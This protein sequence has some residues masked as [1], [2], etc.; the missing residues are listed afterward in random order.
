MG[1]R[2]QEEVGDRRTNQFRVPWADR[3]LATVVDGDVM[4]VSNRFQLAAYDLTSG[5]RKWQSQPPPGPIQRSQDWS[6]IA[7]R[8]L[9]AGNRI[10]ARQLYGNN[11]TLACWEKANGKLLWS[12]E[13]A[14]G[15]FFVSDPVA[16]QG[17]LGL[18]SVQLLSGQ[19][20]LLR[21]NTV[22][23]ESGELTNQTDLVQLR[24]TWGKR[25]CCQVAVLDDS[26]VAV[27]GGVTLSFDAAGK[28]R[29]VRKDV[30][31]PC[32]EDPRWVLQRFQAPLFAGGKLFVTQP[33][34]R[35]VD[36]LDPATGRQEWSV[37]L[38]EVLGIV[39]ISGQRLIVRTETDLRA[40]DRATGQTLWRTPVSELHSFQL[41]DDRSILIAARERT[42]QTNDQWLTRL[43]WLDAATGQP[44]ATCTVPEP[45]GCRSAAG[46]AR[47]AQGP[48]LHVLR[49]RATR[50]QPRCRRTGAHGRCRPAGAAGRDRQSLA[51]A[52][53]AA[54]Y[55][56]RVRRPARLAAF[57]RSRRRSDGPCA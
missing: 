51:G 45:G 38:P 29:W 7:M 36:C 8:P 31:I 54:A 9:V 22:D 24:N 42:P 40:L 10:Y 43:T 37:V 23:P 33:G 13:A 50:S 14:S 3:Q 44:T 48:N 28:V 4:Y 26:I 47:A 1:D 52:C 11:P 5:Q 19:L 16:V 25:A 32:E 49:P 56:R 18:L 27:L 30:T 39:G 21:W 41:V 46:T 6:L 53:S 57:V 20:G 15:E 34:V 17:Q 55:V 12:V 2:P 35:T